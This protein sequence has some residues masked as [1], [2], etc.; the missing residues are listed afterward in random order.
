MTMQAVVLRGYGGPDRLELRTVPR[1]SPG[2]TEVLVRVRA[3]GV[4]DWDLNI[5]RGII[6]N[7][8]GGGLFRPKQHIL[9]LDV[10]GE[11]VEVGAEVSR[12]RVGDRVF[13]D[14]SS[15]GFGGFAEF[16]SPDESALTLMPDSISFVDA[17]ALAHAGNLAAQALAASALAAPD[18]L[19]INGAGG[20]VGVFAFQ[21][22]KHLGV[23][24]IT[25]IDAASKLDLLRELGFERALD[26]REVDFATMGETFDVIIDARS[27]RSPAD[28]ARALT[29]GGRYVTV[30]GE[31]RRVLTIGV[32]RQR[33]LAKTGKTVA[34]VMLSPNADNAE[35]LRLHAA[36]VVAPHIDST[37]PLA[38]T[39]EAIERFASGEHRGKIVVT[40]D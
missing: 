11:V 37:W 25:G 15:A 4:N 30:G 9:G 34:L 1:P 14:L 6:L 36:G 16:V 20:G 23:T 35:L 19:L 2:P 3:T 31:T 26:Y 28:C 10:A 27:T 39:R 22:A 33:M 7:R 12:F 38:Q 40:V 18:R 24:D 5:I 21:L 29:E 32:S 13:G 17:A 8:L